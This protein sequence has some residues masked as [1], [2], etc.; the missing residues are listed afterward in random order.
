MG[1]GGGGGGGGWGLLGLN[2]S[3]YFTTGGFIFFNS[4][5][6][7]LPLVWVGHFLVS[8][9]LVVRLFSARSLALLCVS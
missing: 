5:I 6:L 4:A 7:F 3:Q 8:A 1:V 2:L 9:H